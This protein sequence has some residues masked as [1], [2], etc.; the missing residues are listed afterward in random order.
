LKRENSALQ[1]QVA[2]LRRQVEKLAHTQALEAEEAE[3]TR[4]GEEPAK[5]V[6]EGCE[7]CGSRSLAVLPVPGGTLTVCKDCKHRKKK[8]DD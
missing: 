6:A 7:S 1:K 4:L 5:A 8:L 2:K 3:P